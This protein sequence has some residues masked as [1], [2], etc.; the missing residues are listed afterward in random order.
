LRVRTRR[1][2]QRLQA[3]GWGAVTALGVARRGRRVP[4][5]GI[6][7]PRTPHGFEALQD[8]GSG[9]NALKASI[10]LPFFMCRRNP[11]FLS[12]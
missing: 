9:R 5:L 2:L 7:A 11:Q 4:S 3:A 6:A 1:G 10:C 12:V 8:T